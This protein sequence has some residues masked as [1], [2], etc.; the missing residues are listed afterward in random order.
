M[1]EMGKTVN[2]FVDSVRDRDVIRPRSVANQ[3][4][5]LD[6]LR[7]AL[8]NL[9]EQP[10]F[11]HS[12]PRAE[13]TPDGSAMRAVMVTAQVTYV[14]VDLIRAV[15]NYLAS[16]TDEGQLEWDLARLAEIDARPSEHPPIPT[17]T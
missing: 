1:E 11:D 3:M 9:R 7:Q 13:L 4:Q 5:P 8:E 15:D 6:W 14:P 10:V 2:D 12:L 17:D 16:I